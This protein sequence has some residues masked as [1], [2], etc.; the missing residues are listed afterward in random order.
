[1]KGKIL[2]AVLMCT[3]ATLT[4]CFKD[5]P[6]N[7]ECDI[8]QAYIHTDHPETMFFRA[9]DTLVNVLT[10]ERDIKFKVL[11]EADITAVAPQFR[12]TEGAT[13][14]A[15][16]G[17][18]LDTPRDFSKGKGAIYTVTSQDGRWSK[19]YTVT[20]GVR[21]FDE[22]SDLDFENVRLTSKECY[23]PYYEWVEKASDGYE[24]DCWATGNPGFDVSMGEEG[25][26]NHVTADQFP[27]VSIADGHTGKG[28]KL[29]TCDTGY[30]GA[31]MN[32]RIA[33]GNLF[34]GKFDLDNA[35]TQ[36]L[37]ATMFGVPVSKKPLSFSGYYKYKPGKDFQN[38]A[39]EIQ[40]GMTDKGDIYAVIYRNTDSNGKAVTLD[41]ENVRTSSLI[42]GTAVL[43]EVRATDQ[44]TGFHVDFTYSTP[45]DPSVLARHGYSLAIVFTSSYK[46]AQFEGALGSTLCID[47]VHV[48]WDE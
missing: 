36:T 12:T 38:R 37:K 41:G 19:A 40:K 10:S 35:L 17:K 11:P 4:S 39:G 33:A 2:A 26:G 22:F 5:E 15:N 20:M 23:R 21:T 13:V 29:T 16:D 28:V 32:M 1:M 14:T 8:E 45:L 25:D 43:D 48:A 6:L 31:L 30:F 34:L 24:L 7:A 46:G 9:A 42:V 3:S 27:T 44:W 47:D 18:P